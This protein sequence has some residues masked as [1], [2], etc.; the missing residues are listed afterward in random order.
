MIG[1]TTIVMNYGVV[2]ADTVQSL[3]EAVNKKIAEDP[4]ATELQGGIMHDGV[5]YHQAIATINF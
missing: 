5:S 1:K 4:D 3:I 2:S